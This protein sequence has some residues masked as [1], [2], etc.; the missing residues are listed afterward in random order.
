MFF[1]NIFNS[2]VSNLST[3][4][5]LELKRQPNFREG[6]SILENIQTDG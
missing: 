4:D 2:D 3:I 1:R 6:N 5:T